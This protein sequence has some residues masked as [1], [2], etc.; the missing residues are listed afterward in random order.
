LPICRRRSTT[1]FE[2]ALRCSFVSEDPQA[3]PA[4]LHRRADDPDK[5]TREESDELAARRVEGLDKRLATLGMTAGYEE[6]NTASG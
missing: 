1:R 2:I 6:R 5:P 4:A 3:D